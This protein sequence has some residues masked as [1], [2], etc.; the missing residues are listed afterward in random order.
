MTSSDARSA[1]AVPAGPTGPVVVTADPAVDHL[2]I[3][4]VNGSAG[5]GGMAGQ[6]RQDPVAACGLLHRLLGGL[7]EPFADPDGECLQ[8]GVAERPRPG[9]PRRVALWARAGSAGRGAAATGAATTTCPTSTPSSSDC[10]RRR[11]GPD[12]VLVLR[13]DG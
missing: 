11:G 2:R 10:S 7:G 9:P 8:E 13:R 5:R 1:A 4:G 6:H 12:T 3:R